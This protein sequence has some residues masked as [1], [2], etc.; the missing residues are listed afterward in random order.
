[1]WKRPLTPTFSSC[2]TA[3]A[4]AVLTLGGAGRGREEKAAQEKERL[5]LLTYSWSALNYCLRENQQK[6]FSM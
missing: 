3:A 2:E 5:M 4:T 6:P 1:M